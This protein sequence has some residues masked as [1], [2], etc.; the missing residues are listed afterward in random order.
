MKALTLAFT[1]CLVATIAIVAAYLWLPAWDKE[2]STV[3][4]MPVSLIES[5]KPAARVPVL[6]RPE[7]IA[8]AVSVDPNSSIFA[9][10]WAAHDLAAQ[11]D[12]AELIELLDQYLAENDPFL[13]SNL[14][15]IFLER[16]IELDVN[17]ALD[18]A[19]N[20]T[21]DFEKRLTLLSSIYTSW[22]RYDPLAMSER[23]GTITDMHIRMQIGVRLLQ[24]PVFLASGYE[25]IVSNAVGTH[26][27]AIIQRTVNR[28]KPPEQRFNEALQGQGI[29]R[30]QEISNTLAEWYRQDAGAA[31]NALRGLSE[32]ERQA[33]LPGIVSVATQGGYLDGYE[34]VQE[35]GPDNVQALG[36]ALSMM[37]MADPERGLPYVETHY[38]ETGNIGLISQA[39]MGWASRNVEGAMAYVATLSPELR[40]NIEPTLAHTYTQNN[41]A[42]A[43]NWAQGSDNKNLKM[44]VASTLAYTNLSVAEQWLAQTDDPDVSNTLLRD[45][46]QQKAQLGMDRAMQ[47]LSEFEENPGYK[48]AHISLITN[49][50]HAD[51]AASASYL[52]KY[53]N[54]EQYASAFSNI[55]M[56]WAHS[57]IESAK[58]WVRALPSGRNRD[59]AGMGLI[60]ATAG[61]DPDAA[62]ELLDDFEVPGAKTTVAT[63]L[64]MRSGDIEAAIRR[65]GLNE[66]EAESFRRSTGRQGQLLH[67]IPGTTIISGGY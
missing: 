36:L 26:G 44:S 59:R 58:R 5:E 11:S 22:A 1:H 19:N 65:T 8:E 49:F 20:F 2:P 34:L 3:S 24:D 63:F 48:D 32:S 9:Q 61:R 14:A 50:A 67:S 52:G 23:F 4:T 54:D 40:A 57:D 64:F 30:T 7:L 13:Y 42:A 33:A 38:E 60:Q 39:L 18:Y 41:P 28:N 66:E 16:L 46:A 35:Y 27:R 29:R 17:A 53:N 55:A 43:M 62:L 25:S 45:I 47:W 6:E 37:V 15:L 21:F 31:I 51:P 10:Q 56:K 12:Q